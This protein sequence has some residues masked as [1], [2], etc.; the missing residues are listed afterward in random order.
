MKRLAALLLLVSSY[1]FGNPIDTKCPQ[2]VTWGAPQVVKEGNNQ[3]V[4]KSGYAFNYNYATKVSYFVVERI[5]GAKLV[6]SAPRKDDFRED[7]EIPAQFR[8]TLKD[9]TGAGYDR[10]H[11]AP[12]ADFMYD[13]GLISE[14]FFMTN[15]MPQVPGNNRGIWKYLEEMT[16]YW[17]QTHGTVYVIT[18]TIYAGPVKTIG[19]AVAVPS[20]IYKIVIDPKTGKTASFLFPNEKL[21][22][23]LIDQYA[24]NVKEIES[25]TGIN[26]SPALPANLKATEAAVLTTK[27]M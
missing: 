11:M 8:A 12:A 13:A 4:C 2:F 10:G 5:D 3:Y 20:H 9:Y 24:V 21:D 15:M 23:K 16:R 6:K 26:F 14:S 1:A 7:P 19:N 25:K 18:G 27:D 17:A 22:P